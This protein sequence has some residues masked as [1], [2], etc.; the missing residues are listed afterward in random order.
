MLQGHYGVYMGSAI[1]MLSSSCSPCFDCTAVDLAN[2]IHTS[3]IC[4]GTQ[5]KSGQSTR[6]VIM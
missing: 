3:L 6:A 2:I 1:S 4:K 5:I